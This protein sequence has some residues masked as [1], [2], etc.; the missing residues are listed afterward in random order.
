MSPI[1]TALHRQIAEATA[2]LEAYQEECPHLDQE[3]TKTHVAY[4]LRGTDEP[5]YR[6]NCICTFCDKHWTVEGRI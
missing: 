5:F 6:T 2:A 4:R 1:V 3:V